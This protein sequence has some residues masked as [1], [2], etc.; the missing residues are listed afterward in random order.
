LSTFNFSKVKG[1]QPG[2]VKNRKGE[3]DFV[4][5][6]GTGKGKILPSF[7]TRRRKTEGKT[8]SGRREARERSPYNRQRRIPSSTHRGGGDINTLKQRKKWWGESL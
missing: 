1:G 8:P 2:K 3:K 6:L 7:D 5:R 4:H